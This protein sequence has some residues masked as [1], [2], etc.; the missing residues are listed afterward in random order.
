MPDQPDITIGV[1]GGA[2]ATEPAAPNS[3]RYHCPISTC[4]WTVDIETAPVIDPQVLAHV[5]G[6]G[7]MALQAADNH[8]AKIERALEEHCATHTIVEYVAEIGDLTAVVIGLRAQLG[9]LTAIGNYGQG[10]LDD[11]AG[12]MTGI[13]GQYPTTGR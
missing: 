1:Q 7:V 3:E 10:I 2:A 6:P 9:T 13:L 11:L 12:P 8:R 5:F 4:S